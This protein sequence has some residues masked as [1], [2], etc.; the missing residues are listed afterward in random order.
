MHWIYFL[1]NLGNDSLT[2]ELEIHSLSKAVV[3]VDRTIFWRDSMIYCLDQTNRYNC[4]SIGSTNEFVS[5]FSSSLK[6]SKTKN[7]TNID[8]SSWFIKY[9]NNKDS[10]LSES[11]FL[12]N[13]CS[14]YRI[15]AHCDCSLFASYP[16]ALPFLIL[17]LSFLEIFPPTHTTHPSHLNQIDQGNGNGNPLLIYC[18]TS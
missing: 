12:K 13:H 7:A 8:I 1:V 11:S 16:F 6:I 4:S 18:P 3:L 15:R 17:P 5:N 2:F 10:F 14:K 9:R